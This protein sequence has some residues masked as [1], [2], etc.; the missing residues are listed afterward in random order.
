MPSNIKISYID[1]L[2]G[3]CDECADIWGEIEFEMK[4]FEI[5]WKRLLWTTKYKKRG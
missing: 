5:I 2:R 3:W 1:Q 4:K